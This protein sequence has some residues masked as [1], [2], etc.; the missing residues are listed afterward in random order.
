[1]TPSPNRHADQPK[2]DAPVS[3]E[4][5]PFL[6]TCRLFLP[7]SRRVRL[8]L[9][10]IV[11]CLVLDHATKWWAVV[12]LRDGHYTWDAPGKIF[13]IVYAENT[14]AFLSLGGNLPDP[15]RLAIMI[16]LNA[17][18]LTGIAL[19][20]ACR[21]HIALWPVIALSLVL[22]G[23]LGHLLDRV[24]RPGHVVVDFMNMGI[25]TP[26]FSLRTGIFNIAD[27]AIMGGLAMLLAWEILLAPGEPDNQNR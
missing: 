20:L 25:T 6:K 17:V 4:P 7:R 10:I 14:G 22:S 5:S 13:R 2:P 23:G 9:A 26:W 3:L 8:V 1:M 27:L 11:A 16:G 12:Y 18:I 19:W 24:F 21:R 15:W